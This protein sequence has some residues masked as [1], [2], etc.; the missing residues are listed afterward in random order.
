MRFVLL[1]LLTYSGL[2]QAKV[3]NPVF[4]D[5]C[6]GG[7]VTV[8]EPINGKGRYKLESQL[9]LAKMNLPVVS[10][11][12][13]GFRM[14]IKLKEKEKLVVSEV[15]QDVR[16][17]AGPGVESKSNLEI[18]IAG[19]KSVPLQLNLK[20]LDRT[21]QLSQKLKSEGVVAESSCGN[22][23]ILAGNFAASVIGS[24]KGTVRMFPV[25]VTM[26]IVSCF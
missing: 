8:L 24:G 11:K 18:F 15:E 6:S 19:Q 5:N 3:G 22:D 4:S 14:P 23:V 2:T 26:E 21:K 9:S 10:R 1:L 7:K 17:T 16:L 20:G 25:F 12:S 13:C